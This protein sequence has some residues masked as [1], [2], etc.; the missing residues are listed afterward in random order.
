MS[1]FIL[2]VYGSIVLGPP[3]SAAGRQWR[4]CGAQ[5][6][7][8]VVSALLD[9]MLI[10]WAQRAYG[11]GSLGVSIAIGVAEIA[12]VTCGLLILPR[13]VLNRALGRTWLRCVAAAG[14]T[15]R[16]PAAA[17]LPVVAI[18]ATVVVYLGLCACRTNSMPTC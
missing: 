13:G 15:A 14:A 8:L 2:L 18:P 16:R 12:M 11:N 10:P 9:P 17:R 3:I 1:V 4:W 7:C 5:S 6:L